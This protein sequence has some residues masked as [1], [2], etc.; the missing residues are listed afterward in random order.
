MSQCYNLHLAK[1]TELFPSCLV[2]II[3]SDWTDVY[4][5]NLRFHVSSH[6]SPLLAMWKLASFSSVR[7]SE[8][9]PITIALT[10][11]THLQWIWIS[12]KNL[13]KPVYYFLPFLVVVIMSVTNDLRSV[14]CLSMLSRLL[15]TDLVCSTGEFGFLLERPKSVSNWSSWSALPFVLSEFHP[16]NDQFLSQTDYMFIVGTSN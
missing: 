12:S 11:A 13:S 5:L 1:L 3:V 9:W 4:S 10:I 2:K 6:Q 8:Y 7:T 14:I 15:L 16:V